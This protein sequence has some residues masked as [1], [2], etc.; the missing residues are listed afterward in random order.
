MSQTLGDR[1][2]WRDGEFLLSQC[3]V[4]RHKTMGEQT[5]EAF[6]GGIPAEILANNV[7]HANP[8]EGDGGLISQPIE[9]SRSLF[10]QMTGVDWPSSAVSYS[11]VENLM[12]RVA[13]GDQVQE[14]LDRALWNADLLTL[15]QGEGDLAPDSVGLVTVEAPN[16]VDAVPF[17]TSLPK[18]E[19][20]EYP[21][22]FRVRCRLD[23][24]ADSLWENFPAI[25]NPGDGVELV[26]DPRTICPP[27]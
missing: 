27:S 19:A 17:F 6:P 1:I 14:E 10:E 18:L 8:I 4:C 23:N 3:S 25:V 2:V 24:F 9:I 12:S 21:D 13:A 16:G 15:Q 5:C 11:D 22:A 20:L 7:S 26:V